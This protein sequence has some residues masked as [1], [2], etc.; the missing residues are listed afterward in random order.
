MIDHAEARRRAKAYFS[1]HGYPFAGDLA[2]N[3]IAELINQAVADT[4]EA[5]AQI[6]ME[7]V[8]RGTPTPKM[9]TKT[10]VA[11]AIRAAFQSA[12]DGTTV[13][14][15]ETESPRAGAAPEA[16]VAPAPNPQSFTGENLDDEQR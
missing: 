1:A 8:G 6:A 14:L 15:T 2:V 4:V 3:R 5:C 10:G 13:R 12:K 11:I 16:T 9:L 7:G